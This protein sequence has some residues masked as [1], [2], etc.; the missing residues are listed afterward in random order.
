MIIELV[1]KLIQNVQEQSPISAII[2]GIF[3]LISLIL[4]A[5]LSR[6]VNRVKRQVENGHRT[7]LR[8]EGD[9]RHEEN[10]NKLDTIIKELD[11]VKN[12]MNRRFASVNG[13]LSRLDN[14]SW[15]HDGQIN[16]LE[17]NTQ[18]RPVINNRKKKIK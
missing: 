1:Q 2:Y 17:E 10:T 15:K 13:K 9:E 6:S 11:S 8:E 12:S 3:G 16:N 18:P 4:T 14:R 7:N 5:K